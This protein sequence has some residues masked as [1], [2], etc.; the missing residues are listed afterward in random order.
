MDFDV[1]FLARLQ[2]AIT[3]M[4]H[5]I[6][7]PLTIGLGWLI[8]YGLQEYKKRP[9]VYQRNFLGDA[10]PM[11]VPVEN[12]GYTFVDLDRQPGPVHQVLPDGTVAAPQLRSVG[13]E[14]RTTA[15]DQAVDATTRPKLGP[16]H[17]AG[18]TPAL[19]APPEAPAPGLR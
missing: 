9:V 3:I 15:R 19:A 10:E 11:A 14:E 18:T 12:G 4:F 17:R 8:R 16:G 5:Y 6:F 2:F 1:V 7:P 13:Q